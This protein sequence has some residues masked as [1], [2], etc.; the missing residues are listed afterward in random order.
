[1]KMKIFTI[2]CTLLLLV[3]FGLFGEGQQEKSEAISPDQPFTLEIWTFGS[4]FSDV[5]DELAPEYQ[6]QYPNAKIDAKVIPYDQMH[7]K[8]FSSLISDVGVP[9]MVDIEIGQISRFLQFGAAGKI[10]PLNEWLEQGDYI[11]DLSPGR[12]APYTY[13]GKI[14][15]VEHGLCPVVMYYRKDLMDKY[16]IDPDSLVTWE[17]V[18]EQGSMLYKSEGIS[19]L[20]LRDGSKPG[21]WQDF[22]MLSQQAGGGFYDKDGK[23]IL[24][25]E[26]NVKVM[27][28][29][30]K[31]VDS[32]AAFTA[33]EEH[34]TPQFYASFKAGDVISCIGADWL[35]GFIKNNAEGQEGLWRVKPMPAWEKG[36]PRTA[37]NGGTTFAIT[38]SCEYPQ[39]AWE[40][41]KLVQLT[42][43]GKVTEYKINNLLPP[44]LPAFDNPIFEREDPFFGGQVIGQIYKTVAPEQPKFYLAPTF[45][46]AQPIFVK[47]ALYPIVKEGETPAD[48]MEEAAN[49]I[50]ALD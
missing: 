40:F 8:L 37:S 43:K 34:D 25:N 27:E 1:M 15:G 10:V 7:D 13:E 11:D 38:S 12:V 16:G 30:K 9:D 28:W 4:F 32:G 48:A 35:G 19:L 3:T 18:Y 6:K 31:M 2:M 41:L 22:W 45:N 47:T 49:A 14:L 44:Y 36:G 42:E 33:S 5:Y 26:T 24:D 17:D 21:G 39:A 46:E 20:A 50:R 29:Y 23:V